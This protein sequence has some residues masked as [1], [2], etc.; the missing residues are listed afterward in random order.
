MLGF[1]NVECLEQDPERIQTFRNLGVRIMQLTYNRH[2]KFGDGCL[3]VSDSGLTRA[4]LDAI[5]VM[6]ECGVAVDL[7]HSGYR[8]TADGIARS[9]KPVL[10]SHGGCA[11]V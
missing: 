3:E 9:V 8:A 5:Q 11:A 6:N 10:I 7:S 1:Q 4:G 2:G